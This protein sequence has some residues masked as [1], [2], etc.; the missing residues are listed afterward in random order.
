[1]K[2]KEEFAMNLAQ[3]EFYQIDM[4]YE[5]GFDFQEKKMMDVSLGLS[6]FLNLCW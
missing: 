6:L 1:M 5:S 4:K 2:N 3:G